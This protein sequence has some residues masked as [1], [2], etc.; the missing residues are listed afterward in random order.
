MATTGKRYI[1]RTKEKDSQR[2][3][4]ARTRGVLDAVLR[5]TRGKALGAYLRAMGRTLKSAV[6]L[7]PFLLPGLPGMA[8][9]GAITGTVTDGRGEPVAFVHV[10]IEGTTMG[11]TSDKAG[12]FTIQGLSEG[13]HRVRASSV[14]YTGGTVLVRVPQI[15]EPLSIRMEERVVDLPAFTV[16]NSMT[17]GSAPARD[18]AGS[19]W[20]IGP[21]E[22]RQ[23]AYTD[24]SRMLRTVPGVN[25]QEEDGFGLRPNIGMRGAGAERTS[26][27]TVMEDG[28]LVAPAPYAA[29]AAYYFPVVG[30]MH[31]IE[32]VKGSS[33]VR[34]GPLTTGGAIN[35]LSTPVPERASGMVSLWGGSF[36]M[37]NL[38]A[39]AGAE[40][41][42]IG[43]LVET[44][45]QAA[46]G[47]K[48]LD[49]GG[50]TGFTKSDHLAKLRWSTKP[51]ARIRQDVSLK[52]G[53]TTELSNETYLGL[54]R[55][56]FNSDPYR[57]YAGSAQD[58]MDVEHDLFTAQY[59]IT[60]PRGPQVTATL[61]RTN[62]FRNWYKLDQVVD[63]SGAKVGIATLL[64][65]P[66]SRPFALGVVR[67]ADS[68]ENALLLKANI[69]NYQTSGAQFIATHEVEGEKFTHRMEAG[70]RLHRDYMDRYQHT[71]GYR[72]RGGEMLR[73]SAGRPGTESNRLSSAD[74][75]AA[76]ALYDLRKG[77]V[78][79]RP[80]LRYEHITLR[81]DN[82]G[83]QDPG[84]TG[85]AVRST[86]NTVEVWIPGVGA[87]VAITER[88][89]AFGGVHRGFSPPGTNPE[90]R[91]EAS[92][93]YEAGV[94]AERSGLEIQAIGFLNDYSELLG[95]DM[96]AAGGAGS[97]DLFNGGKAMVRGLE[98]FVA[99]DLLHGR[100]DRLRLP[101]SVAWTYTDA[102]FG[103]TFVS[104]FAGWG[105]V[106]EGDRI[107]YITR[108]QVNARAGIEGRRGSVSL[109]MVRSG[110][111]LS[112]AG[113]NAQDEDQRIPAFTVFDAAATFRWTKQAD[114]FAT[115]QNI[116]G[117]RYMVSLVPAGARPGMPRGVQAGL[118]FRF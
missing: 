117:E 29:P 75:T 58:R 96:A 4:D 21:R 101:L 40:E 81:E 65:R 33:Q 103:S 118:R 70:L 17:G 109:N 108:H 88:T 112:K 66:E 15:G 18:L 13:E 51:G 114:V 80:G 90:T 97:G 46:D 79:L 78:G 89:K 34:Y 93:N 30:R 106:A 73:T 85:S 8:Q 116:T 56:D 64:D 59:A 49:N 67:G 10:A 111:M 91:P 23:Y 107:P 74:A 62:T 48:T 98:L 110:D 1:D 20:Y 12:R 14:G 63:S 68:D 43:V 72:M 94:R 25:I 47:F 100:S 55:A 115:V 22:M 50:P 28:V 105:Q 113:P 102:R 71:D 60:L 42:R 39:H 7:L 95:A 92:V 69:R 3:L 2:I 9:G 16:Q 99:H 45:Q 76:H 54:T 77:R 32:V 24:V 37:R 27:I 44:F 104:T 11:T 52:A 36:G 41:G 6:A 61:Y 35:L 83:T 84:R 5:E 38:H 82:Y 57:R 87:D 26:K 31:G 53:Y 19:A 86:A